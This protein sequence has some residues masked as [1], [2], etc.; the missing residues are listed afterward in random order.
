MYG[1][2]FSVIDEIADIQERYSIVKR[3]V[4]NKTGLDRLELETLERLQSLERL[5]R[6]TIIPSS[7]SYDEVEIKPNSVCYCDIPYKNVS[8]YNDIEFDYDKFYDWCL[9]Q[10][11]LLFISEYEMPDS[12]FICIASKSIQSN[13]VQRTIHQRRLRKYLYRNIKLKINRYLCLIND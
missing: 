12:D 1:I 6:Q 13:I 4:K 8:K 11:Q 10:T 9:R 7:L 5:H 2:D 3:M